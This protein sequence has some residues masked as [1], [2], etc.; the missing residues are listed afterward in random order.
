[1]ERKSRTISGGLR[2]ISSVSGD[3]STKKSR[4]N[5]EG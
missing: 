1:M 2:K 5:A 4:A 3:Q